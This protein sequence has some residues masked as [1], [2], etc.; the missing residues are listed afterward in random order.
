MNL[1]IRLLLIYSI[2]VVIVFRQVDAVADL[3]VN[4]SAPE[5]ITIGAI[6]S[7]TGIAAPHNRSLIEM[8]AIVAER[9][10]ENGGV[11]G[12]PIEILII[13]N[14]SSSIGAL[15]AAY[16]ARDAGVTAVIG[17]HWSSHSLAI[18]PVLN[19]AGIPMISPASTHPGVTK[20]KDYVFRVS[21]TDII[22][23]RAMASFAIDSLKAK[24]SI[25]LRNI[26]EQ[27]SATLASYYREAFWAAGGE[28][29][30]DYGY[31]GTAADFTPLI[32]RISHINTDVIYIPGYSRDTALLMKQ[33]RKHGVT[34]T[35]LGGDGWDMLERLIPEDVEGS[36]Q[37]GQWHPDIPNTSSHFVQQM[38]E[39]VN[40]DSVT[41][42]STPLV[43]DAFM[44]LVEA[45]KTAGSTDRKAI[46]DAIAAT[47]N[48][49]GTTGNISFDEHGDLRDTN[50]IIMKYTHGKRLFD[51]IVSQ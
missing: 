30:L 36:Y 22:Q 35:F 45:I 47:D 17:A 16:A 10:N 24:T 25:I 14:R 11:L 38:F 6:F 41:N 27:Y 28:V 29:L 40:G 31:R 37:T 20:N 46:R 50:V 8:I 26:D 18:A 19:E 4:Y 5:P 32:E 39:E 34:A 49:L 48:Y 43:Y 9:V 2:L 44:V 13:D 7:V 33:A 12:R 1:S 3:S 21:F 42:Y 15:E 23:G 51:T